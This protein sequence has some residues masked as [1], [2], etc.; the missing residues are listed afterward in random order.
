MRIRRSIIILILGF[1]SASLPGLDFLI[2]PRGFM[3]IPLGEKKELYTMGGGGEVGFDLDISSIFPTPLGFSYT[4]GF[5]AGYG[6]SPL[7]EGADGNL[8]I[9]AAG[10]GLGLY[11][12]PLS[13][14]FLRADGA[15]GVY[16]GSFGDGASSSYWLRAGGEGGF[17][18]S[19]SFL[20]SLSGGWRYFHNP[21]GGPLYSGVY[22][23]LGIQ[24]TLGT[25]GSGNGGVEADLTQDEPVFPVFLSLYRENAAATL[26]ISNRENAEIRNVRVSFRAGAYTSSEFDCGR[27]GLI[28]RGRTLEF[29]LL[30]DFSPELLTF[31]EHS[32]IVGELVI[33]YTLLGVEKQVIRSTAIRVLN[34]NAYRWRDDRSLAVFA[35]PSEPA[36]LETAKFITG[37][38]RGHLKAGLN[39]NMQMGLY[40]FEG[41]R[42]A[43]LALA[44]LPETPYRDYRAAGDAVYQDS[45]L[46][47]I[48]FPFQTLAYRNGDLDDLGLL[49]GALL[50]ASGISAA[51]I[52][53]ADDFIIAFNLGIN[54]E[55]A[56][57]LFNGNEK[58]LIIEDRVW[59]PL[60]MAAFNR[61]FVESWKAGGQ[62]VNRINKSENAAFFVLEEAWGTYPP[63]PVPLR[64][65]PI[66]L[67]LEQTVLARAD[68]EFRSYTTEELEPL[69][70]AIRNQIRT[71]PTAALYNRLGIL[72]TRIGKQ[73]EAV[74]AYEHAIGM[75][76]VPAMSNRGNMA[77][78][79]RDYQTAEKWFLQALASDPE[80]K[81]A[82]AGLLKAQ[83]R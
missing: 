1:L 28:P 83:G 17:R 34:R 56:E 3:T 15:A 24:I 4:A 36:V 39:Q 42:A 81:G 14:L 43:G 16:Q 41:L 45:R 60:S 5:E 68:Q 2:R 23:G 77:L 51:F 78:L 48:Q 52:S 37:L 32:R 20:L 79:A 40:L 59:L 26:K 47:T 70:E 31:T 13:R 82:K 38:A 76:S 46:D 9:Y 29:P 62:R 55:A 25:R 65:S 19:P 33:R 6:F 73:E 66:N 69:V 21:Y 80:N 22:T 27:A 58:L 64:E 7:S 74:A 75:G 8:Q 30:A 53:L 49:Y 57:T 10:A 67:P 44:E 12:F 71:A 54:P 50:E 61:G 72:L 35:S 11:Y 63:A 18:F